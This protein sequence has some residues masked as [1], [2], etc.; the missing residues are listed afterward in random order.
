MN[1]DGLAQDNYIVRKNSTITNFK[2]I[3]LST[4]TKSTFLYVETERKQK[5]KTHQQQK[6]SASHE[7][8]MRVERRLFRQEECYAFEALA[9]QLHTHSTWHT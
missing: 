6:H 7:R 3:I 9:T 2:I 1:P 5:N 8:P 4:K